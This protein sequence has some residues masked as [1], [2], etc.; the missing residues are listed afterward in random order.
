MLV[1]SLL[2]PP[3]AASGVLECALEAAYTLAT[4]AARV[5]AAMTA[6][7][8]AG[9]PE[10]SPSAPPPPIVRHAAGLVHSVPD[11]LQLTLHASAPAADRATAAL[12]A[13]AQLLGALAPQACCR[14]FLAGGTAAVRAALAA[15]GRARAAKCLLQIARAVEARAGVSGVLLPAQTWTTAAE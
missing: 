14:A 9:A 15:R 11:L 13:T 3:L 1:Q 4:C 6:G 8:S 2:R 10:Y 12:S 7:A 5:H